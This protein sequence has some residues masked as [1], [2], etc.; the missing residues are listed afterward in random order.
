M[1]EILKIMPYAIVLVFSACLFGWWVLYLTRKKDKP[2]EVITAKH[3][4]LFNL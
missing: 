2:F 4:K 1:N 3:K